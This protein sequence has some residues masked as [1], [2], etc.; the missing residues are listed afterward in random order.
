MLSFWLVSF[1]FQDSWFNWPSLLRK[2]QSHSQASLLNSCALCGIFIFI[3]IS[4]TGKLLQSGIENPFPVYKN[5]LIL[6]LEYS[7]LV[8]G[9]IYKRK[10]WCIK[11]ISATTKKINIFSLLKTFMYCIFEL[12]NFVSSHL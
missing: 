2:K 7:S 9:F 4:T 5:P 3:V 8:P 11:K 1:S 6:W 12:I 10:A